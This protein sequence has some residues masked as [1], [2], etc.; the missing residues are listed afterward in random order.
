MMLAALPLFGQNVL[1][2]IEV[3]VIESSV[4]D[5]Q[6][7]TFIYQPEPHLKL[8]TVYLLDGKENLLSAIGVISNLVRANVIPKVNIVG[9]N[10]YDY[11][12]T[13]DLTP[14]PTE[15][16]EDFGGADKFIEFIETEIFSLVEAQSIPNTY[17]VLVGH[18]LG[19]LFAT[20]SV[21]KRSGLFDAYIQVAGSY[22]FNDQGVVTD[23]LKLDPSSL[24]QKKLYFSLANEVDTKEGFN[25]L[26]ERLSGKPNTYFDEFPDADHITGLIPSLFNGLQ[27]IFSEWKG[28]DALY[29]TNNFEGVKEKVLL[30][31]KTYKM[32]V[33]P[34]AVPLAGYAR[35]LTTKNRFTESIE[36]LSY[37]EGFHPEHIM[38]LNYL[39]EA[40][41]KKGDHTK[42]KA[43]YERSLKVA[44]KRKSPMIRWIRARLLEVGN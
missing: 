36:I 24:S 44:E 9:I 11:D 19:G 22:W 25:I 27:F 28:W 13:K 37:L 20:Y 15:S 23:F 30:L 5:E 32:D 41:Q 33:I 42:A 35:D 3:H 6:R 7:E 10:N 40:Y 21:I 4:L 1:P 29:E 17:K 38:V 26:K 12:R 34:H 31:E 43:V 2:E 16:N 14:K 8:P 18:S 39:G